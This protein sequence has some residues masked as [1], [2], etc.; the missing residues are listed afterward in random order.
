MKKLLLVLCL[1]LS[2]CAHHPQYYLYI[3][4]A[5]GCRVCHSLKELV[6]DDIKEYYDKDIE[7]IEMDIDNEK[8]IEAYAKTCTLLEGYELNDDSGEV[9][10][11][12]LDGYFAKVGFDLYEADLL[13]EAIIESIE[14]NGISNELNEIY[15]FK[16][17]MTYRKEK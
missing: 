17:N 9:P 8:S 10:F 11:L 5:K 1:L 6:I 15:Y 3:Y 2:S 16:E 7:I 13:K 4:Y 14:G 12:V